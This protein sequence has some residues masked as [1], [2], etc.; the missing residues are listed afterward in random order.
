MENDQIE[1]T[2]RSAGSICHMSEVSSSDSY[3]S[4][5]SLYSPGS[6]TDTGSS[7]TEDWY[8]VRRVNVRTVSVV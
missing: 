3:G 8:Q 6:N 7:D 2:D 4:I 5:P 1:Q